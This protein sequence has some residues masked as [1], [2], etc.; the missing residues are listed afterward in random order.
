M[1]H[2]IA[3]QISWAWVHDQPWLQFSQVKTKKTICTVSIALIHGAFR[4]SLKR[5]SHRAL[6]PGPAACCVAT[7]RCN[8]E[9]PLRR[10]SRAI[11][12]VRKLTTV[13]AGRRQVF[14]SAL[15]PKF[16]TL[17]R[18]LAVIPRYD[19]PLHTVHCDPLI[20]IQR[21]EIQSDLEPGEYCTY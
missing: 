8:R 5:L 2:S 21:R 18:T 12:V 17:I 3:R 7:F 10:Q 20:Q 15:L 4:V 1:R 13:V 14:P 9:G 6:R 11:C 19:P 16:A